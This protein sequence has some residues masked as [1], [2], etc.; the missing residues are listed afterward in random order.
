MKAVS[1]TGPPSLR[2]S[3]LDK[4]LAEVCRG[5]VH[6][7]IPIIEIAKLLPDFFPAIRRKFYAKPE[8]VSGS[9]AGCHLLG[10]ALLGK[11]SIDLSRFQL[12]A[13]EVNEILRSADAES[14]AIQL[15][16]LSGNRLLLEEDLKHT[17]AENPG[18]RTL[19]LLNTPQIPLERK[20]EIVKNA[21]I[22]E[23][24]DSIMLAYPFAFPFIED[25]P[26]ELGF[27]FNYQ[28]PPV[29]Q[30][31]MFTEWTNGSTSEDETEYRAK[32]RNVNG[33]LHVDKLLPVTGHGVSNSHDIFSCSFSMEDVNRPEAD[34]YA[35]L[36]QFIQNM[37]TTTYTFSE[38]EEYFVRLS[39]EVGLTFAS[40]SAARAPGTENLRVGTMS[41]SLYQSYFCNNTPP[42]AE[43][44]RPGEWS[45]LLVCE[46]HSWE[47]SRSKAR[48][49][50]ISCSS[51][52]QD[53]GSSDIIIADLPSFLTQVESKDRD[54]VLAIWDQLSQYGNEVRVC[55]R[56]EVESYLRSEGAPGNPL[57]EVLHNDQSYHSRELLMRDFEKFPVLKRLRWSSPLFE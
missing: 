32:S 14:N 57:A 45:L 2:A 10:V 20:L 40:A 56:E 55:D 47:K 18:I 3:S 54:Q 52:S 29:R 46:W 12:S 34:F 37:G 42:A 13:M 30:I 5:S 22:L 28:K 8:I 21:N 11:S 51:D 41:K 17:L 49:A 9:L 43:T 44:I 33:G 39:K 26:P 16:S 38:P 4:L 27:S 7:L 19:H 23:L 31:L 15:L 25:A 50:F 36:L 48:Y 24:L 6:D 1:I 35:G 53:T